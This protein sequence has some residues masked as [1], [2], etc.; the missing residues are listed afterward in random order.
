MELPL[1]SGDEQDAL[2]PWKKY[3]RWRPGVRKK[4][5]RNYNKRIRRKAKKE[6]VPIE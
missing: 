4:I 2:T 1:K 5:K 3:L 6:V